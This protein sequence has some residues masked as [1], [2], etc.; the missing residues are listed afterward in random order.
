MK[1]L[2]IFDLDGTLIDTL[3]DLKNSVNYALSLR[4]YP[5]RSKE[6][7]RKAIGNGV[8]K[9]V[10]RSIPNNESNPDYKDTLDDFRKHYS[11][12]SCVFTIPYQGMK[13]VLV[14]LKS[15]GYLLAVA[16]N[17]L[18]SVARPMIEG[19][20]PK[21]FDYIQGD[22]LGMDR[23]PAPMM[24][25]SLCQRFDVDKKDAFYIGDTNVDMQTAVNSGVDF[26]LV[27][28][29]Y[30]TKEELAEQCPGAPTIDN[31]NQLEEYLRKIESSN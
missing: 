13:D 29:G 11:K 16:T 10:A 25:E 20:F 5:L 27:T 28:Y 30:R 26:V 6:D 14:N 24:V 7:I 15:K 4:N 1:K 21:L 18:S 3:K 9:L 22:E 8:A 19:F 31:V 17:K 12:N 23:K 2:L